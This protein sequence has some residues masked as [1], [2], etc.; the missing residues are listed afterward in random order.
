MISDSFLIS[1]AQS[2]SSSNEALR[3]RV[4]AVLDMAVTTVSSLM[5]SFTSGVP[6]LLGDEVGMVKLKDKGMENEGRTSD[7]AVGE[8][9]NEAGSESA[10]DT[11]MSNGNAE[12][13]EGDEDEI[14]D[15]QVHE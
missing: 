8:T 13:S 7:M 1:V 9:R 14:G 12:G 10:Q 3:K 6:V 11:G 15:L 4:E 2:V 5:E